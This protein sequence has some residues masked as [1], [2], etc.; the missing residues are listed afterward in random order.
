[1]S[2][3]GRPELE[4]PDAAGLRVGVV[5]TSWHGQITDTLLE[6]AVWLATRAG[7]STPTVVRVPGCHRDPGGRPGAGHEPRRGVRARRGDPGRHTAFRVRLRLGDGR[8]DPGRAGFRGAGRQR[9]AD[10]QHDR[11]GDRPGRRARAPR[12]TR[13]PSR[14]PPR[15][16][17]RWCCAG[18][19]GPVA[20]WVSPRPPGSD[21]GAPMTGGSDGYPGRSAG[22]TGAGPVAAGAVPGAPAQD[23][24]PGRHRGRRGRRRVGARRG[25]AQGRG[26]RVSRSAPPTRSARSASGWCWPRRS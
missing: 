12:R 5:A 22:G 10:L 14:C 25:A 20:G 13:A 7:A 18:C 4:I 23:H 6:R 19:A 2:G 1:M 9:R 3:D 15:W 16:P 17:P 21:D 26:R 11:A 8:A 24:H